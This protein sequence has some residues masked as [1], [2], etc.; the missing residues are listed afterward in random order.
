MKKSQKIVKI[1]RRLWWVRRSLSGSSVSCCQL[2][3]CILLEQS[4]PLLQE[5]LRSLLVLPWTQ[6]NK[7]AASVTPTLPY[8]SLSAPN[9]HYLWFLSLLS[10]LS[11]THRHD[12]LHNL[13]I[14]PL[15]LGNLFTRHV[16]K[17]VDS[18]NLIGSDRTAESSSTANCKSVTAS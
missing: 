16:Q 4:M 11:F 9:L 7:L 5:H 10:V 13:L 14:S 18:H 12:L 8:W 17:V 2:P 1:F 6:R 3:V 15:L